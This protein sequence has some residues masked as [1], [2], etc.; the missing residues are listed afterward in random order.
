MTQFLQW[1][2]MLEPHLAYGDPVTEDTQK[3][4][5]GLWNKANGNYKLMMWCLME[6]TQPMED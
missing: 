4:Y 5:Y 3:I 2:D 1:V 6:C